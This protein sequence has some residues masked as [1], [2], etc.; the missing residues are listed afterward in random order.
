MTWFWKAL[1]L[2]VLASVAVCLNPS[3][4]RAQWQC[5]EYSIPGGQGPGLTG[6]HCI[7]P[8]ATTGYGLFSN[9]AA[10]HPSFQGFTASGTG[11][12][13]RS[14]Q[15]KNR[16]IV[17]VKD[18]GAKG[19]G[20]TDDT[21]AIQAALDAIIAAGG[22][23]LYFPQPDLGQCYKTI[24]TLNIDTSAISTIFRSK[25]A[26]RGAGVGTCIKNTTDVSLLKYKGGG[27][28]GGAGAYFYI[29]NLRLMGAAQVGTGLEM[30]N[31]VAYARFTGLVVAGFN[32]GID[33]TDVEQIEFS[34]PHLVSN[35][36]GL[37]ARAAVCCTQV[38]EWIF[39]DATITNNLIW[40]M[41][42][43]NATQFSMYGG[44]LQYNGT[45]A[46]PDGA[47]GGGA[48][49][50]DSGGGSYGTVTFNS[51]IFEG[52]CGLAD[53]RSEQN[54]AGSRI[55]MVLSNVSFERPGNVYYAAHQL[56]IQGSIANANYLILGSS[57]MYGGAYTPDAG[58]S[59]IN[60][61]N[62]GANLSIDGTTFFA[63]TLEAPAGALWHVG[64]KNSGVTGALA[65]NGGT[66]GR[67][68]VAVQ[69]AAGAYNFN[70][71][72]TIG[73]AG[74]LL[75]SAAGGGDGSGP[76]TWTS[77]V[78]VPHGGTG[79]TSGTSGGI[80]YFSDTGTIASSALLTT[81]ALIRGGGAG[82]APSATACT[83]GTSLVNITCVSSG[84]G[85]PRWTLTNTTAD[86][87]SGSVVFLKS[88]TVGDTSANDNLGNLIAYGYA[89][90][91]YQASGLL[92]VLQDAASSG[93]YIPSRWEFQTSSATGSLVQKLSFNSAAH[94]DV[95]AQQTAPTIT[96]GCNGTGSA[97]VGTDL[98]ANVTGK[99]TNSTTCTV[100][101]GVAF[102][103]V[104]KCTVS[105]QT[106]A[107][108]SFT[109]AA[110]TIVVTFA[111]TGNYKWSYICTGS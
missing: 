108:T 98:S 104:P 49:F 18:F 21:A 65:L 26:L 86:A 47:T 57:F 79:L 5:P 59:A 111:N 6:F 100:T 28:G 53:L 94:L 10:A 33:A 74:D 82:G 41:D 36:Y 54:T 46:C 40:G 32:I 43:T 93:A 106:S 27:A 34:K 35:N 31:E 66:S 8:S 60:N 90:S 85:N 45:G 56:D 92:G 72:T 19:D 13:P 39:F 58:R 91:N 4:A 99:N 3:S 42:V 22:G 96:A 61:A 55:N 52:N 69:P 102:A 73:A 9:G 24:A 29:D 80:P 2:V 44:S 107:I 14:W 68:T 84:S 12:A 76:M 23:E 101:F 25:I 105:G 75:T 77:T 83:V 87:A 11:A 64:N 51:T 63:S 78:T 109:P 30:F 7:T 50:I 38:S 97:I 89:S 48:R 95:T 71:P 62:A 70:L 88:R 17:S 67:V 15:D 1:T 20:T 37:V 81:N 103:A 110:D 16:D